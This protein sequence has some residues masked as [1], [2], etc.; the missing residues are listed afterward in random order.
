V[1]T[2][3]T[4]DLGPFPGRPQ[5][6]SAE[7]LRSGRVPRELAEVLAIVLL[8]A[9]SLRAAVS[10]AS[11][12]VNAIG[13][14]PSPSFPE[15]QIVGTGFRWA[16]DFGDAEGVLLILAVVGLLWWLTITWTSR[17]QSVAAA[18]NDPGHRPWLSPWVAN[19]LAHVRR[20]RRLL[21][22]AALMATLTSVASLAYIVSVALLSEHQA[23]HVRWTHY[24]GSGGFQVAYAMVGAGAY[25]VT[26]RLA[27]SCPTGLG[28]PSPPLP[29]PG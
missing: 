5:P 12:L 8:A 28:S 18:S 17:L 15:S 6:L 21:N 25:V 26:R 27:A 16:A 29:A 19:A 10:V 11:G 9:T 7:Y 14:V 13:S 20:V 4:R 24:V 1:A 22:W 23:A 3:G 2:L